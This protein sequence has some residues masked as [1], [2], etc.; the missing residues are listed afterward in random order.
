MASKKQKVSKD[1]HF[2]GCCP[3][4]TKTLGIILIIVGFFYVLR[5]L[6]LISSRLSIWPVILVLFGLYLIFKR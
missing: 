4:N 1:N 6:G 3:S 5:E 2:F